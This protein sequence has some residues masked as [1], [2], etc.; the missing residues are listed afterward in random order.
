MLH[1]ILSLIVA[2]M[3]VGIVDKLFSYWLD[4]RDKDDNR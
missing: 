3:L 2:P 4:E 1:D